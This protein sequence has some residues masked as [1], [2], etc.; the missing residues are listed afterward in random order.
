ME[1][2][3]TII[4]GPMF[5]GKTSA[6]ISF[7]NQYEDNTQAFKPSTDTRFLGAGFIS[8]HNQKHIPCQAVN[9]PIDILRL[10]DEETALVLIDEV[11]FFEGDE[12][13]YVV[14]E[15]KTGGVNVVMAGV[16]KDHLGQPFPTVDTLTDFCDN[17]YRL[18]GICEVCEQESTHTARRHGFPQEGILIGGTE[19]Y[20]PLCGHCF[21]QH[22][23]TL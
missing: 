11:Q 3:T 5:A 14:E 9:K 1:N 12:L 20:K 6:L 23:L 4:Y 13:K 18:V 16:D 8:S 22:L 7:F 15:L 10:V 2:E 17:A 21:S 19:A